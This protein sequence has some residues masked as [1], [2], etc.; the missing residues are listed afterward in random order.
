[1]LPV[2]VMVK[3]GKGSDCAV[4]HTTYLPLEMDLRW[5]PQRGSGQ[6]QNV[7][8]S[9]RKQMSKGLLSSQIVVPKDVGP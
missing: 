3:H 4:N 2:V 6:K 8:S 5:K 7:L 9:I 1:M